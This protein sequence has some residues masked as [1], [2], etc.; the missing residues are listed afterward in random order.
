[1]IIDSKN[2]LLMLMIGLEQTSEMV[3]EHERAE[4]WH[5]RSFISLFN[6]IAEEYNQMVS[7]EEDLMV[8]LL[9]E[10]Y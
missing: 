8:E 4:E 6:R 3:L 1:M 5:Q 9:V 7:D 2:E 10:G